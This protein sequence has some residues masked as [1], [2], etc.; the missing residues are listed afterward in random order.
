M[1]DISALLCEADVEYERNFR[2][3]RASTMRVGG[4][5]AYAVFPKCREEMASAVRI[6]SENNVRFEVIGNGSNVF[7]SDDGF[8]GAVILCGNMNAVKITENTVECECGAKLSALSCAAREAGLSGLEFACG[9][10]GSVG[11]SV[12]MNAGAYG[13]DMSSVLLES[14]A[15]DTE[16]GEVMYIGADGH[17]F[18]YRRSIYQ[19]KNNYICLSATL[20]LSPSRRADI[21]EKMREYTKSRRSKQPL[22]YPSCG[23]YFKRPEGHYAGKLIEDC[24][25]KGRF[26]GGAQVSEK[27]AGFII[28]KGDASARDILALE[29]IIKDEVYERFGVALEREV[30]YIC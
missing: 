20:S 24:G 1:T 10:P 8:D 26:V 17:G 25:L 3:S 4:N 9:I 16:T 11:G 21:E 28:N 5:A 30:K 7:F 12:A 15:L 27:H 18:G 6:C 23:S 14:V 19:Q 22:E 29:R 13:T 2:L